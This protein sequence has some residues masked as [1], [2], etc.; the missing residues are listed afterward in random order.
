MLNYNEIKE[1]RDN[2]C[3]RAITLFDH[4]SMLSNFIN[5]STPYKGILLFH[6]VGTGKTCSGIAIAEKFKP[7]VQKYNTKIHILVN[8]PLLK[9]NWKQHLIKCTGETY[10]KYLDKTVLINDQEKQR[11]TNNAINQAMQYYRFLSFRSFY[12]RVLGEKIIERKVVKGEKV[13]VSYKKTEE[14]DFEREIVVEEFTSSSLISSS[15]K[16]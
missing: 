15:E 6:N 14:G 12:K 9:E 1:Y 10:L 5:P 3:D 13:K 8:G 11:Q 7:L 2:I 4:Q 16:N